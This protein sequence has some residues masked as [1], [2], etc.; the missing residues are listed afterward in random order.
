LIFSF[1]AAFNIFSKFF[2]KIFPPV[3][4]IQVCIAALILG[5]VFGLFLFMIHK[6]YER[7]ARK[8]SCCIIHGILYF[9]LGFGVFGLLYMRFMTNYP[10]VL[11]DSR[12]FVLGVTYYLPELLRV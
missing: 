9:G 6:I 4:L 2:E 11:S 5:I 3:A 7:I 10:L 8:L 1:L 12:G